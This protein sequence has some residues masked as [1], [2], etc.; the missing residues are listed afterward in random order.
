MSVRN[1][2]RGQDTTPFDPTSRLVVVLGF[3]ATVKRTRFVSVPF[4]GEGPWSAGFSGEETKK[5]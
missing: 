2:A 4:L 5:G 1:F 3:I